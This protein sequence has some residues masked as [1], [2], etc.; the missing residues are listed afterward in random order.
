MTDTK[1]CPFCGNSGVL[2]R[3]AVSYLQIVCP[4]CEAAAPCALKQAFPTYKEQTEEAIRLWNEGF[5]REKV[6][7]LYPLPDYFKP[8][9]HLRVVQH[10][11]S[12]GSTSWHLEFYAPLLKTWEKIPLEKLRW[13]P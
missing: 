8:Y 4:K 2:I 5:T 1:P 11:C 12:D 7:S 6:G 9:K 3:D 13:M 10:L